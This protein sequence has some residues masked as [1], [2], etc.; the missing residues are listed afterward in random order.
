[1]QDSGGTCMKATPG[2]RHGLD[3]NSHKK[4]EPQKWF[5]CSELQRTARPPSSASLQHT[6]QRQQATYNAEYHTIHSIGA[7]RHKILEMPLSNLCIGLFG[8]SSYASDIS[9]FIH[10]SNLRALMGSI[11]HSPLV[12]YPPKLHQ[13][14]AQ[15]RRMAW[16]GTA[17]SSRGTVC[18]MRGE[19]GG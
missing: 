14:P 1:V 3:T 13:N 6:A 10:I 15:I 16:L 2:G 17:A 19:R 9:L 12:R 11:T 7:L 8:N 5:S 4:R 18:C